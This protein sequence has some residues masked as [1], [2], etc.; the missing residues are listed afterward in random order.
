VH[1]RRKTSLAAQV[2]P[3]CTLGDGE[4]QHWE[5][6]PAS[7]NQFGKTVAASTKEKSVGGENGVKVENI[8]FHLGTNQVQNP[9]K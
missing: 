9:N 5:K 7:K 8:N 6:Q 2:W 4:T 1:S 3:V